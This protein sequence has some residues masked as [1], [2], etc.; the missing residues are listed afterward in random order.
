MKVKLEFE[1]DIVELLSKLSN[2]KNLR[3]SVND[4]ESCYGK[5]GDNSLVTSKIFDFF[6]A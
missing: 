4:V 3:S 6:T 5:I 2:L 1:S